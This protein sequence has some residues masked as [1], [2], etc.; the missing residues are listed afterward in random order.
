MQFASESG[1]VLKVAALGKRWERQE[2]GP[3]NPLMG[4]HEDTDEV[5]KFD[6]DKFSCFAE[7]QETL[8]FGGDTVLR[9]KGITQWAQGKWMKYDKYLEAIN[10]FS[11]MMV[12]LSVKD[13]SIITKKRDQRMMGRIVKD[14]LRS[15]VWRLDDAETPKYVHELMLFHLSTAAH[16][17]LIYNEL[18]TEYKWLDCIFKNPRTETLDFANI[19]LLF[20]H[21]ESITF[22][23]ADNYDLSNMMC[24]TLMEDL[25]LMTEMGLEMALH[26]KWPSGVPESTR[27]SL[28]AVGFQCHQ[29]EQSITIKLEGVM[30]GYEAQTKFMSRIELLIGSLSQIAVREEVKITKSQIVEPVET[31][32]EWK[33]I[34][35]IPKRLTI[36][37]L[38]CET[39]E[40]VELT[41]SGFCR[42]IM[43]GLGSQKV[44][45][46]DIRN[47]IVF[48][49]GK[50]SCIQKLNGLRKGAKELRDEL[51]QLRKGVECLR[52]ELEEESEGTRKL[53]REIVRLG[54][55]ERALRN[56]IE[57]L[58]TTKCNLAWHTSEEMNHMREIVYGLGRYQLAASRKMDAQ[59]FKL[60]AIGAGSVLLLASLLLF[61][62]RPRKM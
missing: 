10:V 27:R 17:Q 62:R 26:F 15:L 39:T 2:I 40:C 31:E 12:G 59:S 44:I 9:I 24:L 16:I 21:S 57:W 48:Y 37:R 61:I 11:R 6:C 32:F 36:S 38:K 35:K 22:L 52:A 54:K 45:V 14:V 7:E 18:L 56:E 29:D 46:V 30:L 49:I 19:A 50:A 43:S 3:W 34:I 33:P 1:L 13:Q 23:M 55:Q 41:V 5:M 47:M 53:K 28:H 8:F 25:A 42:E 20:C 4:R 58:V 60:K 51:N